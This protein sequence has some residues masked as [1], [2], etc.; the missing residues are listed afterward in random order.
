MS[1]PDDV[2]VNEILF[3]PKRQ[4]LYTQMVLINSLICG[5]GA[6]VSAVRSKLLGLCP[7]RLRW[8]ERFSVDREQ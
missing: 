4:E 1:Q 2:D 7:G 8:A 5:H 6:A 3:R